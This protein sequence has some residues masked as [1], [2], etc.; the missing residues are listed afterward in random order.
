MGAR[1]EFPVEL[2][3]DLGDRLYGCDECQ[4]VCP[5][6]IS[7]DTIARMNGDYVRAR[8]KLGPDGSRGGGG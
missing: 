1:G 4:E 8:C 2:R 3:V 6:Q 7:I 5:K